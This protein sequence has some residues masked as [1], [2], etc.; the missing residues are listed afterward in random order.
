MPNPTE[1]PYFA[2]RES[3]NAEGR[4]TYEEIEARAYQLYV[5]RGRA[6]G[7]D[8][9]DW[10]QAERELVATYKG[11]SQKAKVIGV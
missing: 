1:K 2:I 10:L 8:V 11:A 4:P 9:E 7:Q 5:E 3:Q 6:D